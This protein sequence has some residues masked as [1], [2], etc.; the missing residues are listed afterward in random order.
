[1]KECGGRREITEN[2]KEGTKDEAE[3]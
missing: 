3:V 1:M 2:F